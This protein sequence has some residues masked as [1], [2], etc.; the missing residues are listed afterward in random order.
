MISPRTGF[1]TSGGQAGC[2]AVGAASGKVECEAHL[3]HVQI[4]SRVFTLAATFKQVQ[5]A[6]RQVP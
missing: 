4:H 1:A 5:I 2:A 6:Q 3:H